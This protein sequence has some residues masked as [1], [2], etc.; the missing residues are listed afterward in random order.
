MLNGLWELRDGFGK[1]SDVQMQVSTGNSRVQAEAASEGLPLRG[2]GQQLLSV[3]AV[4]SGYSHLHMWRRERGRGPNL[5][6]SAWRSDEGEAAV[7]VQSGLWTFLK[8]NF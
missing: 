1:L 5:W 3:P 7:G 8:N 6:L 2:R 4:E